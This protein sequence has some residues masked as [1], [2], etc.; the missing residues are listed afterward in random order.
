MHKILS[1]SVFVIFILDLF[2]QAS[3][4]KFPNLMYFEDK[5]LTDKPTERYIILSINDI[6]N[7]RTI[8][9]E[10][11]SSKKSYQNALRIDVVL[12]L[13][14]KDILRIE[15]DSS[16]SHKYRLP[17]EEPFPYHRGSDKTAKFDD[18][19]FVFSHVVE[20]FSLTVKRKSTGDVLFSTTD[21]D[22]VMGEDVNYSEISTTL[23]T[24][25]LFGWGERTST[26]RLTTGIYTIWNR[27]TYGHFDDQKKGG[28]P[29]YGAHPMYMNKEE[30]GNFHINYLRNPY[31]MDLVVSEEDKKVTWKV[32]GG[33]LDFT[34]FLGDQSPETVVKKYH[35]YLGGYIT[36][37]FWAM[38]F[39]QSRWGYNNTQDLMNVLDGYSKNDIP[40]DT[41]W[42]DIDYMFDKQPITV[43]E[44]RYNF[45]TVQ[46]ELTK[47]NKQYVMI[48]EPSVSLNDPNA[49][50]LKKGYEKNIFIKNNEGANLVNRVWPG[51]M[52]FIDYFNPN[53]V[54]YWNESL[55]YL[56]E[57]L[58]FSGIWL[59]MNEIATF[60]QGQVNEKGEDV[61]CN[62]VEKYPYIPGGTKFDDKTICMNAVLHN[63]QR[64]IHLHNYYGLKQGMMTHKYLEEKEQFKDSLPFILTRSNAAG[65]GK[66]VFH[67]TGDNASTHDFLQYSIMEIANMNLFGIPMTGADICGFAG[68]A[69]D[70][71]FCAQFYQIGSLFPFSRSHFAI[72]TN[73]KEPYAMGDLLKKTARMSLRFRYSILKYYYSQFLAN[74]GVG[75][76]FRPVYYT[77]PA[78]DALYS[79]DVLDSQFM[80]GEDL[81]VV[82][83]INKDKSL[84]RNAYFPKAF[85]FN[86]RDH[87]V[88]REGIK[89]VNVPLE[90]MPTVY[91]RSGKTI[92]RNIPDK[93]TNV[94]D[95]N[96]IF[97]LTIALDDKGVSLG[98]MPALSNYQSKKAVTSCFLSNC[99]IQIKSN[100]VEGKL[101]IEFT[102][103]DYYDDAYAYLSIAGFR[104]YGFSKFGKDF[105]IN[106]SNLDDIVQKDRQGPVCTFKYENESSAFIDINGIIK[107]RKGVNVK[108]EITFNTQ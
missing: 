9:L 65:S 91:L 39:H 71:F 67:W 52:H 96:D 29:K 60:G 6:D 63:N 14:K 102:A 98:K 7:T 79:D 32:A 27:D 59:D 10:R 89:K 43:D 51:R 34:I 22:I 92:F 49:P 106:S 12:T 54:D 38:G 26:M 13:I 75:T 88:E 93:V 47:Q 36:P 85:W 17:E 15:I 100:F 53:S 11:I 21:F 97:Y 48:A 68:Q 66:Y 37:P 55:D 18:S 69:N 70:E 72:E 78:E 24:K 35:A 4:K 107:L 104:L 82:P 105:K 20:P 46:Q 42:M 101:N 94:K 31:P 99:F 73:P 83:N 86:L 50:F 80:I 44:K 19:D 16:N 28:D 56:Y 95:L 30:H 76:I 57:K 77:F 108:A 45:Q 2:K 61:S 5:A 1:Y 62:D 103:A 58:R 90:T 74:N 3:S 33:V 23:N 87:S 84:E 40:F 64:F 41:L 81:M 8:K 25:Y